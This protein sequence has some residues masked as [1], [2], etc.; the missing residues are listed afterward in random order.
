MTGHEAMEITFI[1]Q[2]PNQQYLKKVHTD[3]S[4]SGVRRPTEALQFHSLAEAE[5]YISQY[6]QRD[7]NCLSIV[8]MKVAIETVKESCIG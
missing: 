1:I 8:Q 5:G 6:L 2:L 7:A 4:S 3:G